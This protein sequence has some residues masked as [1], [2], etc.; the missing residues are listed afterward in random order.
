MKSKVE[1]KTKF[2]KER[3]HEIGFGFFKI[4]NNSLNVV[5]QNVIL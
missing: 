5:F 3:I 4:A 1:T 2:I